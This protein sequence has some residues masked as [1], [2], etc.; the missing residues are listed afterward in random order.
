MDADNWIGPEEA[1]LLAPALEKMTQLTSLDLGC[2]RNRFWAR[3][4][5]GWGSGSSVRAVGHALGCDVVWLGYALAGGRC[6]RRIARVCAEGRAAMDAVNR[7][8]PEGAALLAPTLEKMP[9]LTSLDLD[10][11]A[12]TRFWARRRELGCVGSLVRAV[13]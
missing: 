11:G 8:G 13:G 3:P 5:G 10:R 1:A 9:Q 7:I 2:A 4:S 6:L 12:R